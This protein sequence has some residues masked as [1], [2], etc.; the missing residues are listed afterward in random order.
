[1]ADKTRNHSTPMIP[2]AAYP[3]NVWHA[4]M[5]M[6]ATPIKAFLLSLKSL[7]RMVMVEIGQIRLS[8]V[9]SILMN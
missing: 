5:K 6:M 7:S 2:Y 3:P 4:I 1:M 8:F 9:V